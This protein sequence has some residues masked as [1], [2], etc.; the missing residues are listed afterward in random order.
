MT[1]SKNL[2]Q[3]PNLSTAKN[4][5]E[6]IVEGCKSLQKVPESLKGL[7]KLKNSTQATAIALRVSCPMLTPSRLSIPGK[8]Y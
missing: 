7:L 2:I 8:F 1:G 6:L 3:L 5:E 4:F